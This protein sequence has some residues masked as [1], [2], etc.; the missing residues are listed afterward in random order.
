MIATHRK[1]RT[2]TQSPVGLSVAPGLQCPG[3]TNLVWR[4][5]MQLQMIL[6]REKAEH[7]HTFKKLKAVNVWIFCM[8]HDL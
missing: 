3:V 5:H 8:M 7:H 6:N 1:Q 4:K 2:F